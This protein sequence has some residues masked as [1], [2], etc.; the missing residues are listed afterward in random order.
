MA[1]WQIAGLT[2]EHVRADFSCGK[3]PL[4]QFLHR[5]AGQYEKK[6]FGRTFVATRPGDRRVI[7]YHTLVAASVPFEQLPPELSRKLPKHPV[8]VL[9]LARL[10][11]DITARGERLGEGLLIDA[12]RRCLDIADQA[13]VYAIIVHAKDEEAARFYRRYEFIPI[14]GQSLHLF[15][16]LATVRDQFGG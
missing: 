8:P 12:F 7:G 14:V 1:N 3:P 10:A 9:L 6:E 4:D 5:L 2:T 11:V 16:P 13:G 15:L